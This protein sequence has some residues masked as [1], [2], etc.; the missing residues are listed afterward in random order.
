MLAIAVAG[1]VEAN[2][3]DAK[4]GQSAEE[5]GGVWIHE[6]EAMNKE[7]EAK[8][9]IGSMPADLRRKFLPLGKAPSICI[10]GACL[11]TNAQ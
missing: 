6:L 10:V 11:L 7:R 5:G 8:A 4:R 1:D 3:G 2:L 9:E